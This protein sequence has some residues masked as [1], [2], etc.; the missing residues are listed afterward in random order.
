MK[1]LW[2]ISFGLLLVLILQIRSFGQGFPELEVRISSVTGPVL[3]TGGPG[4]QSLAASRGM[5]LLPGSV[6]DTSGGGRAVVS[7]TDG[8]MVVVQP[9][10]V[11]TFKDFRQAGSLRELFDITLGQVRVK[12]NHFAG[13][14]NPYRMNSPTASIAVRGTE[15]SITVDSAG[16]TRVV[17]FEGSV[18]V[19][20][21]D[22][23][24]KRTLV[25]TGQGIFIT[26]GFEI[27]LFTPTA[28]DLDSRARAIDKPTG[29]GSPST[30]G[31]G[32]PQGQQGIDRDQ[33]S[34]QTQA[35]TYQRYIAGL[36]SLTSLPLFLRYNA[37]PDAYLD[38]AENPAYATQFTQG[39]ARI[40]MLPSLRGTPDPTGNPIS[41]GGVQDLASAY[42]ASTQF[43]AFLPFNRGH[44]VVGASGTASYYSDPITSTSGNPV[45][46]GDLGPTEG[47]GSEVTSG[48]SVSRFLDGSILLAARYGENSFGVQ[49]DGLKGN[50]SLA[51]NLVDADFSGNTLQTSL[52]HSDILQTRLTFGYKREIAARHT[53]GIFARYGFVDAKTQDVFSFIGA[54][55]QPLSQTVS[56]GHT[57]EVGIRLRGSV[58]PKLF[59]G[60]ES[61]WLGLSLRD[62]LTSGSSGA[63]QQ[64]DRARRWSSGLGLGYLLGPRTMLIGDFGVGLS[65]VSGNRYQNGVG[66]LLQSGTSSGH[67]ESVHIALQRELTKR[68]FLLASF[69]NVWEGNSLSYSVFPDSTGYSQPLSDSLFSTSPVSYQSPRHLSDFGAGYRLSKNLLAQYTFST[70]YGY[71]SSS[72]TL[73]LRFTFHFSRE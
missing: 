1:G 35:G 46:P 33:P 10:S 12:I 17:V 31:A 15:F 24:S 39:Q 62:S 43:S 19:T 16:Q 40:Y 38:S 67:F 60:M 18:E 8:S 57:A 41:A 53:V 72:H 54:K 2:A 4:Q 49:I 68:V 30:S 6:L 14:P 47:L 55:P 42:S 63:S 45:D 22:D 25:E 71:S 34:P 59:Y 44:M 69:V 36:E 3:I 48:K 65:D 26:P 11:V 20:S 56:P 5:A 21:R 29:G 64:Q 51:S 7:L 50:G 9:D 23:P 28:R 70:N 13:R 73:M 58:S 32:F 52:T 37:I 61:G 66:L 27:Q